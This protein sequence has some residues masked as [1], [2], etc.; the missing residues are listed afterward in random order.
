MK[1][2]LTILL[3]LVSV[4]SG[5]VNKCI[6]NGKVIYQQGPCLNGSQS[7][8]EV[9]VSSI[10]SDGLRQEVA[11]KEHEKQEQEKAMVAQ[12]NMQLKALA[13]K[14]NEKGREAKAILMQRGEWS[15]NDEIMSKLNSIEKQA[16]AANAN[17]ASIR[18][19]QPIRQI[20][21]PNLR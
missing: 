19:N 8:F 21:M 14:N 1:R 5:A 3:L 17:S 18:A 2:I 11:R 20:P 15:Q 13:Y 9:G 10:G 4:D 7:R 6:E 16:K 12:E